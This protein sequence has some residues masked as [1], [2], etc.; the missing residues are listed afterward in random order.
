MGLSV[1]EPVMQRRSSLTSAVV[2]SDSD[3]V[4]GDH[5]TVISDKLG[6]LDTL[7]S[8]RS[9]DTLSHEHEHHDSMMCV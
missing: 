6:K 7:T 9:V 5:D 8:I 2:T 1:M 3:N 4:S